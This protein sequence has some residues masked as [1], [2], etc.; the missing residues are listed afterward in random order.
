MEVTAA[1]WRR[2]AVPLG[3]LASGET[4]L[5]LAV[6]GPAIVA[7]DVLHNDDPRPLGLA[8]GSWKF[9]PAAARP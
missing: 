3:P 8:V 7:G 5:T 2:Y 4:L 1:Q 9:I 6:R